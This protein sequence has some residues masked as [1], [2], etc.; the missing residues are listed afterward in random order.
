MRAL[1]NLAAGVAVTLAVFSVSLVHAQA[2]P[3]KP[4]RL[5]IPFAAGGPSD[6]LGRILGKSITEQYGVPVVVES[7]VGA[8]GSIGVHAAVQAAPDGYTLVLSTPDAITVYPQVKKGVPYRSTDLTPITLV[9]STPYVF[10]VNAHSPAKTIKEFVALANSQKLAM[11][12]Q[13][14]GSS[15]HIVLEMFKRRAGIELLHVPY[16]GAGPALQSVIADETQ[17]TASSPITL[18]GQIDGGN[19]R[20]LAVS[21]AARNPALPSVPSMIESGFPNF[22]VG[23]WFGVFAPPGVPRPIAEKLNEMV[24]AAMKSPDYVSRTAAL[25]L[26]ITPV[27]LDK[28]REMLSAETDRWKQLIDSANIRTEE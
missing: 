17:I 13:G 20:A 28:Y 26:D 7:K 22:D 8:S 25:G 3:S 6:A 21:T 1:S 27:S 2:F 15:T 23:S 18:K 24:L 9:A 11:G 12:T 19:L 14:T 10:A 16:R 5:I 4:I